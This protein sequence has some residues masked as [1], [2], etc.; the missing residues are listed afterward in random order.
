MQP[1]LSAIAFTVFFMQ[2]TLILPDNNFHKTKTGGL[3][4]PVFVSIYI[5]VLSSSSSFF[6]RVINSCTTVRTFFP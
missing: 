3:I 1:S 6:A 4:P 2:Y 5:Q